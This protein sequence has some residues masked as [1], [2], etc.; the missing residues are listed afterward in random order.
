MNLI[1]VEAK[2]FVLNIG[3]LWDGGVSG[4]TT[5]PKERE[6]ALYE[7]H[8]FGTCCNGDNGGYGGG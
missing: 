6:V 2:N 3:H 4:A 8:Y 5:Y 1:E 7:A